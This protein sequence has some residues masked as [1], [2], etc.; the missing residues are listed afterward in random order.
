MEDIRDNDEGGG[1]GGEDE[2]MSREDGQVTPGHKG[3]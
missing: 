3:Q 2:V 1:E